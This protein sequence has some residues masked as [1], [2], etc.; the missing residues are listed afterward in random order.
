V[1]DKLVGW[2]DHLAGTTSTPF[3]PGEYRQIMVKVIDDRGK[4]LLV[5]KAVG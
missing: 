2:R 1:I 3:E 4:E 5:V